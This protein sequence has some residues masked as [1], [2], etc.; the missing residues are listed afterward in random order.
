MAKKKTDT[1][2]ID[3]EGLSLDDLVDVDE[4]I[5]SG[6]DAVA[7]VAV[8]T[9]DGRLHQLFNSGVAASIL[10]A[11]GGISLEIADGTGGIKSC[12]FYEDIDSLLA[13]Q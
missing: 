6:D 3:E 8:I 10:I 13:P 12:E 7:P 4:T 2:I 1:G 9:G 5:V 11:N